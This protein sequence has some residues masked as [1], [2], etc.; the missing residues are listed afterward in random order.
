MLSAGNTGAYWQLVSLSLPDQREVERPGLSTLR[1]CNGHG[2][3]M[4][5][6]GANAENTPEHLHQY[7]VMGSYYAEKMFEGSKTTRGSIEQWDG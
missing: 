4:L 7:A 3:D 2:Y 6:L 1:L 5:D